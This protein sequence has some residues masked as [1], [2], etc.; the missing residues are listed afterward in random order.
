M[1]FR[2]IPDFSIKFIQDNQSFT[3]FLFRRYTLTPPTPLVKGGA[4][5]V[6]VASIKEI[7]IS[8]KKLGS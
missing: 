5:K 3:N 7:G 2:Q 8:T 1:Y 6:S 4:R